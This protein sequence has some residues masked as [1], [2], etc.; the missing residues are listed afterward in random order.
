MQCNVG[1]NHAADGDGL[2]PPDR[3]Q[4][5]GPPDLNVDR[6]QRRFGLF[7]GKFMRNRPARSLGDKPQTLLP[8]EPVHLIDDPVNVIRKIGALRL[9]VAIMAK[10][11]RNILQ[12][13]EQRRHRNAPAYHSL[14]HTKLRVCGQIT[15]VAPAMGKEAQW[16]GR[17]NISILLP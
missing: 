11:R 4:L 2:Q 13:D 16:P 1:D 15:C 7:R 6:F 9:D 10:D 14:H 3:G 8:I 17:G 12:A 5:A